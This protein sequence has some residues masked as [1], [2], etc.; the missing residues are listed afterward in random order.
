MDVENAEFSVLQGAEKT[1][2]NTAAILIEQHV[3]E[4]Y[5]GKR[6]PGD[7]LDKCNYLGSRNFTLFDIREI[8]YRK[9]PIETSNIQLNLDTSP[10]VLTTFYP[11][12]LNRE[13]DFRYVPIT[14]KESEKE[15]FETGQRLIQ[16]RK[17]I[18]EHNRQ[19]I[20]NYIQLSK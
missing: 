18:T 16:R 2:K 1:L 7:F 17:N 15:K 5:V 19:L 13:Y 4:N 10:H 14:N 8:S 9:V 20:E 3:N 6:T 11:V 12:F